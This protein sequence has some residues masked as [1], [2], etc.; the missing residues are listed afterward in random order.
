MLIEKIK[1]KAVYLKKC[2][3]RSISWVYLPLQIVQFSLVIATFLKIND[4]SNNYNL[5]FFIGFI[6]FIILILLGHIDI[7]KDF[8]KTELK[9]DAENNPI[10]MEIIKEIRK[11]KR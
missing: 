8:Y 7:E 3:A 11:N 6:V 2:I 5:I 1:T 10:L 4:I 9:I